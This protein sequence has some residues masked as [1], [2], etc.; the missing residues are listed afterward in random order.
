[1]VTLRLT[2]KLLHR[3]G[4]PA[5]VVIPPTTIL[6]DWF[7]HLFFVGHRRYVLLVSDRSR[8]PVLLPGR[9]LKQLPRTF[10]DALHEVLAGLGLPA[11]KVAR[12][13]AESRKSALA[14]TNNRSLVGTLLDFSHL[15]TYRLQDGPD[16]DPAEVASWLS[17]TPVAPLRGFPDKVTRRLFGEEP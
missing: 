9:D 13:V 11:F 6:G 14:A 4:P 7:G 17:H 12:E 16:A 1:M 8:L 10:P 2:A 3:V 5:P 15:L